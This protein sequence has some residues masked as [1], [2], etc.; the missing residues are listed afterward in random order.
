MYSVPRKHPNNHLIIWDCV[1]DL[2]PGKPVP[3]GKIYPLSLPEQK[4]MEKYVEEALK[5]GYIVPSTSPASSSCFFV[6]KKDAA[7]PP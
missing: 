2:I 7:L 3:R 4:V 5:K 6:A 1:I